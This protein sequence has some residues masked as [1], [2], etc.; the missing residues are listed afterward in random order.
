MNLNNI[1]HLILDN[2]IHLIT[3]GEKVTVKVTR[4]KF[5]NN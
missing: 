5:R 3:N 2:T 1:I 4:N